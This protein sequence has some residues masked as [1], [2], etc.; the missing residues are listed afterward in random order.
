VAG[1]SENGIAFFMFESV[2]INSQNRVSQ[3]LWFA[4]ISL[5]ASSSP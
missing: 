5:I 4:R 1:K 2:G 3:R